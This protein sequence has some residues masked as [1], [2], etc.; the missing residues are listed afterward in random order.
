V[1]VRAE[2]QGGECP[3]VGDPAVGWAFICTNIAG[4]ERVHIFHGPSVAAEI[5]L[6]DA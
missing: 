3:L 1:R 2:L 6:R 4:V 5:F